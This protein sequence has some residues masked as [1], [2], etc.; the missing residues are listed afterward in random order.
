[1]QNAPSASPEQ[2]L[3]FGITGALVIVA[4]VAIALVWWIRK[5]RGGRKAP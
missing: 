2:I 4:I 3:P 1:M 5:T